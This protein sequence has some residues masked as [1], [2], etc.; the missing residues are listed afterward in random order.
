MLISLHP[1]TLK[2]WG[3][4]TLLEGAIEIRDWRGKRDYISGAFTSGQRIEID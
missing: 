1:E 3:N 4:S 2:I